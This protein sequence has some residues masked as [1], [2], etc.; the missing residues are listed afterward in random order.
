MTIYLAVV[1]YIAM[2]VAGL[3]ISL[4][5]QALG[6]VP[7][8]RSFNFA[9]AAPTWNYT[10]VLN[11]LFLLV[12]VI[13]GYRF[14][15][16]GGLAMLREMETMPS[17]DQI[18]DPVCGMVVDPATALRLQQDEQTYWFCS[19]GCRDEFQRQPER[20]RKPPAAP[21]PAHRH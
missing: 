9:D 10:T 14:L 17:E 2:V 4:I 16:T 11:I 20:Y 18:R 13:L 5:F 6:W 15:R 7:Q 21:E 19:E 8:R 3:V 12:V 1:S